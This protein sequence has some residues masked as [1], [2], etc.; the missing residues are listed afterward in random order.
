M[1]SSI[2]ITQNMKV[3]KIHVFLKF[4]LLQVSCISPLC[5][6]WV[7]QTRDC[8][9]LSLYLKASLYFLVQT[10]GIS[11]SFLFYTGVLNIQNL[12]NIW[13]IKM[14]DGSWEL[15]NSS[16]FLLLLENPVPCG[17]KDQTEKFLTGRQRSKHFYLFTAE[18]L[19]LYFVLSI[20][21]IPSTIS[22]EGKQCHVLPCK[23]WIL[24]ETVTFS[25]SHGGKNEDHE[26]TKNT[27]ND[28]WNITNNFN[29]MN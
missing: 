23:N 1:L 20:Q 26:L 16:A 15:V 6:F 22:T 8:F 2:S 4:T 21:N 27:Q 18:I 19:M 28:T 12:F 3:V 10:T 29:M 7:Q 24:K 17:P 13:Y 11:L 5:S 9:S 14:C 25:T